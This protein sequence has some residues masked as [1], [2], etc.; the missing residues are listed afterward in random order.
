MENGKQPITENDL[1]D[2]DRLQVDRFRKFLKIAH[3]SPVNEE[4]K[5]VLP[6]NAF[7]Y[8]TGADVDPETGA[9]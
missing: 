9:K 7:A 2:N 4:G 1:T 5:T 3:D 6:S 8:A